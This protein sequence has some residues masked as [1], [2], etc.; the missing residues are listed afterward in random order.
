MNAV[1]Q[2]LTNCAERFSGDSKEAGK[3]WVSRIEPESW[4][5]FQ[6][7]GIKGRGPVFSR[8]R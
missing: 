4:L 1:P 2:I 3:F 7:S 6:N 8:Y 5:S